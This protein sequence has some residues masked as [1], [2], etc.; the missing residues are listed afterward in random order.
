MR[1]IRPGIR[2]LFSLALRRGRDADRDVRVE[3]DTHIALRAEQLSRAGF[4]AEAAYDEAVRRFGAVDDARRELHVITIRRTERMRL[5]EW[6]ADVAHDLRHGVRSLSREPGFSA[7]V[8]A[9][10]ALGIGA[11]AAMFGVVDRLMLRGPEHIRDASRVMRVQAAMQPPGMNVLHTGTFG[12]VTYDNLQT[13]AKTLSAVAAY[14]IQPEGVVVGRGADARRV[15]RGNATASLFPLL[16]VQ[17]ARGR[18]FNATEDDPIAPQRVA[19]IGFGFWQQQFGGRDNVV[20]EQLTLDNAPY[21][22]IGVAPKG[23]TGPELTR[24]D[25][26]MPESL[27]THSSNWRTTWRSSW[28]AVVVRLGDGASPER[29]AT[30]IQAVNR[31]TYTDSDSTKLLATFALKPVRFTQDGT[32]MTEARVSKWL[33]AVA[34]IV[35]IIA[36]ANVVNLLLARALRRRRE[37]AV[38]LA[39]GAGRARLVRLLVVESLALAVAGG[40]AGVGVAFAMG[41]AMRRFLIPSVDWTSSTVDPRVIGVAMVVALV[42]G[43]VVGVVPALQASAPDLSSALKAGSREGGGRTHHLRTVLTV[44]QTALSVVLLIGAGLFVQ[45]LRR[46]EALDLGIQPDRVLSFGIYRAGFISTDTAERRRERERRQAFLQT[47]LE[48]VRARPEVEHA[49]L[50]IGLAF[51]SGFGDNIRVPGRDS[52]PRLKG[53]GPYL[54]AVTNDYL[55]TVGGR[56]L[57]G[58]SFTPADRA[59]SEPVA[60][61]DETM[62]RTIWPGED[63]IG[64]CFMVGQSTNCAQVV[65]I[66]ATAKRFRIQEEEALSFYIPW[67]QEQ[68]LSGTRLLVRP[69]VNTRNLIGDIRT[70]LASLDPSIIFVSADLM[71]DR[72]DPQIRPWRLGATMLSLMGVLALVV[73]AIGLYSLIAYLVAQRRHEIGIRIALGAQTRDVLRIVLGNALRLATAGVLAGVLLAL[74]A[75]R[76]VEPLL[77]ETSTTDPAAFGAAIALLLSVAI[78]ASAIP[79]TRAARVNAMEAMRVE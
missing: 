2:R 25:V 53:G 10:L 18:F 22:V 49:S 56:L 73:A 64:K 19:V 43:L 12:Y 26:W 23:F 42:V 20:G 40:L 37:I 72:V 66:A 71:Q 67:G 11:N 57:R 14:N 45:S 7:F 16:G 36:G 46:V 17:A 35:L 33:F 74:G 6:L 58:R 4:T 30:E 13:H 48:R 76:F 62:A 55:E 50:T 34:A 28:L 31:Q 15:T 9:T 21:T 61:I 39:L 63:P 8:V 1:P 47:A 60:I 5:H 75:A 29:A 52:I 70:D 54:N 69:R 68:G 32:E 41:R 79:G 78:I 77:F 44:A 3:I 38:R 59:G 24:V 51:S 65:G 27:E